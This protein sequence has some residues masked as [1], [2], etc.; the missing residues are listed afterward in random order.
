MINN[1]T[2]FE[3]YLIFRLFIFITIIIISGIIITRVLLKIDLVQMIFPNYE[4]VEENPLMLLN[5]F[6]AFFLIIDER[7][8]P[9]FIEYQL[10]EDEIRIKT[11]NPHSTRWESPFVLW[12][13]KKRIK[14]L[15]INREEYTNYNLTI[16][17]FG[18]KKELRLQKINNDGVYKSANI[19]IS[20]LGQKKYT[21]LIVAIDRLRTK[22]CLN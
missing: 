12:G 20:L 18:I 19:N 5:W 4:S 21:N 1:K 13:Y 6:S 3:I 8:K 14:V 9:A 15:K 16:G 17:K 22:I 2:Q 10:N 11:Y 7:I